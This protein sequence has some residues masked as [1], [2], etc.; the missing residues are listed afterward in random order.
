[1]SRYAFVAGMLTAS[2]SLVPAGFR[3]EA[4]WP[5]ESFTNLKV[6]PKD[7]P[8][9]E[10]TALM[11]SFTRALGVRCTHCHVGVEG[12]PLA[13]YKFAADDKTAKRTARVMIEMVRAIN[14]THL[15]G[16]DQRGNPPVKVEC[17]TCHRG[18]AEPRMLQDVLRLEYKLGGVEAVKTKYRALRD[19]FYGRS[20]YDFGE[21]PLADLA[22]E[23]WDSGG[24]DDGVELHAF[25][26]EM[27]PGSAFAKRQH[28]S[29]AITRSFRQQGIKG[30]TSQYHELRGK[31]GPT[32]FVEG[33]LEQ[34]GSRLLNANQATLAIEAFRLNAEAFP[35]SVATHHRLGDAYV[36]AGETMRAIASYERA[37]A[38]E[39][40]NRSV[41]EKLA[42]LRGG[43]RDSPRGR[44]AQ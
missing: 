21:V 31:Y 34:I 10:L 9:D 41:K 36:R 5:P 35:S 7:I 19:R 37:L 26:V 1:M 43:G 38:L 25:N 3:A 13:T 22:G 42:K 27:N 18:T 44:V 6:L 14:S 40:G 8:R 20:T 16:L 30:G 29:L 15:A 11:A 32:V 24:P 4:Q 23:I 28:A 33:L 39:P 12:Q 2:V 17:A